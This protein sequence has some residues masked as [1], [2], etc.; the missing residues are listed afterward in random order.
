[1]KHCPHC[2]HKLG[3]ADFLTRYGSDTLVK[4]SEKAP[5]REHQCLNC[6]AKLSIYYNP[7]HFRRLLFVG[8]FFGFLV[9]AFLARLVIQPAFGLD[10]PKMLLSMVILAFFFFPLYS[11]WGKYES[12]EL[13]DINAHKKI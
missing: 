5:L 9:S 1:M 10:T 7:F 3:F 12:A 11:V 2:G 6:H 13:K 8:S 4:H